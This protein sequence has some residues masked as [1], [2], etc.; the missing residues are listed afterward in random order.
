MQFIAID[1]ETHLIARGKL[2]PKMVCYQWYTP[3]YGANLTPRRDPLNPVAEHLSGDDYLIGWNIAYDMAVILATYPEL[4]SH[5]WAKYERGQILDSMLAE[6]LIDLA[7]GTLAINSNQKGYYSLGKT[8]ARYG[9]EKNSYDPWRLRY[10]ELD[11][12][13]FH[14]WPAEAIEYAT[15]D[16]EV[17]YDV[18]QQQ[19][20]KHPEWLGDIENQSRSAWCLHLMS[21]WGVHTDPDRVEVLRGQVTD[22]INSVRIDLLGAGLIN[23][24]GKRSTRKA[25]KLLWDE[26]IRLGI[27]PKWTK[28]G[29]E[30][31]PKDRELKDLALDEDACN[32]VGLDILQKYSLYST[33]GSLMSRI[34]DLTE[35][36]HYPLQ[37]SFDTLKETGRTSSRKPG[38]PLKGT[39]MQ[40]FPRK[41]GAREC[42]VPR[43]GMC[44]LG[45]DLAMTELHTLAQSCLDL[46]GESKLADSLNDGKDVHLEFA[47]W[48][49]GIDYDEAV[50]RKKSGDPDIVEL[51]STEA[52][53]CNFGFP[54]GM[55]AAR[56]VA[57]TRAQHGVNMPLERA[58]YLKKLWLNAWEMQRFFN[59]VN[60]LLGGREYVSMPAMRADRIRGRVGYCDGCNGFFQ[61]LAAD[62]MKKALWYVSEACYNK[63]EN[64]L[65]GW[66]PWNLVHDE[67]LL[68][69]PIETVH[70]AGLELKRLMEYGFN[71]YV[72]DCPTTAD[73]VAMPYWTKEAKPT[74]DNRGEL[75]VWQKSTT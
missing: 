52:K 43:D 62:G 3:E 71:Q 17:T 73:P 30:K 26:A 61:V 53:W 35:G 7:R 50:S 24:S 21:C 9:Y 49:L 70:A 31:E 55:G 34:D 28:G 14:D 48:I 33:Q 18:W 23:E 40:N 64:A 75:I 8:A 54:G 27:S 74:Y 10:S 4:S 1:T 65:Y 45:A 44:F 12:V 67:L 47:G 16:V 25:Q 68:E 69:G 2:A 63:P 60:D 42:L 58:Q 56:F 36:Y 51:R 66:R 46:F 20:E 22:L 29:L 19:I 57:M 41:L 38:P 32:Q 11:G 6:Q 72:P 13:P 5:V 59:H 39:Q 15:H 37:S